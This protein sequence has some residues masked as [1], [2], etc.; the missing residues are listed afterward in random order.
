[1]KL[2][3]KLNN[4]ETHGYNTSDDYTGVSYLDYSTDDPDIINDIC[5]NG[6][7]VVLPNINR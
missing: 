7:D 1:L 2:F 5:T 3:A 4:I 6:E